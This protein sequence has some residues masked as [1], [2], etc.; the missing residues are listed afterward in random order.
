[1]AIIYSHVHTKY[2]HKDDANCPI[3]MSENARKLE[4]ITKKESQARTDRF[5]NPI[6]PQI[7]LQ[8]EFEYQRSKRLNEAQQSLFANPRYANAKRSEWITIPG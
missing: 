5:I 3:A 6:R 8:R 7:E 2:Y 1:M 4:E